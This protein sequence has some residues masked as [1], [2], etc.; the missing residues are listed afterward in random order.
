MIKGKNRIHADCCGPYAIEDR[1]IIIF[2]TMN[3]GKTGF[4]YRKIK[5]QREQTNVSVLLQQEIGPKRGSQMSR[6]SHVVYYHSFT[7]M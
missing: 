7:L 1:S 5:S 4:V 3:V 6:R 2:G